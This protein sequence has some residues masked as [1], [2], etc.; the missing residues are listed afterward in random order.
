MT[1]MKELDGAIERLRDNALRESDLKILTD[2]LNEEKAE[3]EKRTEVVRVPLTIVVTDD[4]TVY[5][6]EH[7]LGRVSDVYSKVEA[8]NFATSE[9]AEWMRETFGWV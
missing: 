4:N 6:N 5:L 8:A 7:V 1:D 9:L 3:N 2:A